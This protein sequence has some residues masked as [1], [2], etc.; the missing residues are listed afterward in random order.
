MHD[1]DRDKLEQIIN[2]PA[3]TSEERAVA[4]QE[5][6]SNSVA[7]LEAEL[8]QIVAKP[9]LSAVDYLTLHRFCGER[10]WQSLPIRELYDHWLG[11]YFK[12]ENG[13]KNAARIA[14]YLRKHDFEEWDGAARE[15][16]D[17]G[18][19]ST[20]ARRL[21]D[22]LERIADSPTRGNYHSEETVEGATKFLAEMGRRAA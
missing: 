20:S 4:R 17:S 8:L 3:S 12:T 18:F 13:Q 11:A 10:G 1:H 6:G 14:E 16:R 9:D 22:V 15:W 7:H 2:D 5:M 21:I 19:K